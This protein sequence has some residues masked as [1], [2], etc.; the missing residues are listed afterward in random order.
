MS[1]DRRGA[2]VG[3]S[4]VPLLA[5]AASI[6]A[7]SIAVPAA[8]GTDTDQLTITATVLSGCSLSGGSL[9]FGQYV[10]GQTADLDAVG[11]INYTNCVGNLRFE[12]DGGQAASVTNRQMAS[13]T[14]RLRY[15]L[16][17]NA[18]RSLAWGTG[19]DALTVLLLIP[20]NGRVDVYGRI[21]GGQGVAA[22]T[23]TDTVNI[24]L[25]F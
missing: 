11:Q 1:V 6:A 12:L 21:L 10:S 15:Q 9:T 18:P 3:R 7:A 22:G 19:T 25:T 17:R 16:F 23:Y 14:A 4:A 24:T 8:A 2:V 13:G 20:Q 5:V